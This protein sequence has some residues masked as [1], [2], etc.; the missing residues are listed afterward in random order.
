MIIYPWTKVL[1]TALLT[2]SICS[3]TDK[4][5]LMTST[6]APLMPGVTGLTVLG[7]GMSLG[8]NCGYPL[9]PA[10]DLAPRLF[11]GKRRHSQFIT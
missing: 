7:L 10:R 6:S 11:M 9:N 8:F 3:V 1:A 4:R 5:N 2:L